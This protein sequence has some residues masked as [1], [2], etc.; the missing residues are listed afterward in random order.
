[1]EA[2]SGGWRVGGVWALKPKQASCSLRVLADVQG[3]VQCTEASLPPY[4]PCQLIG[5]MW[6]EGMGGKHRMAA[7]GGRV[8]RAAP[9]FYNFSLAKRTVGS[10]SR[11]NADT[12]TPQLLKVAVRKVDVTITHLSKFIAV[13]YL[14]VYA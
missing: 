3:N 10:S 5:G 8:G 9:L 7:D 13:F 12:L 4:A 6:G 11:Y 14:V 1:M 2:G